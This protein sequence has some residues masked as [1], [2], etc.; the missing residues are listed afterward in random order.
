MNSFDYFIR[1][2]PKEVLSKHTAVFIPEQREWNLKL[3]EK[4]YYFILCFTNPPSAVIRVENS[5]G[6]AGSGRY[7]RTDFRSAV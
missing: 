1:H 4:E 3:N 5:A 6:P 2:I 7:G